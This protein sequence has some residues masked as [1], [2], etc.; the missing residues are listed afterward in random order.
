M[1]K[2]R[3]CIHPYKG[4]PSMEASGMDAAAMAKK[5]KWEIPGD[6]SIP[7]LVGLVM[8]A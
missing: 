6:K 1:L 2:G 3:V 8:V 5:L 4:R 7:L